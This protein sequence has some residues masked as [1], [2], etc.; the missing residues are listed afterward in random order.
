LDLIR[1]DVRGML[2]SRQTQSWQTV[3]TAGSEL[4]TCTRLRSRFDPSAM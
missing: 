2:E 3:M 1:L 4:H